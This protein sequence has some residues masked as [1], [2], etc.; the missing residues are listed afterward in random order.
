MYI[1]N[2]NLKNVHKNILVYKKVKKLFYKKKNLLDF[3]I[4]FLYKIAP[5]F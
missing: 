1:K 5:L 3:M 4:F 2:F